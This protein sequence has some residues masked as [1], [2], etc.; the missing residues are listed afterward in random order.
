MFLNVLILIVK[1]AH[2]ITTRNS[3][4]IFSFH[5]EDNLFYV[6]VEKNE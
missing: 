6:R 5:Y 1:K 2:T 4:S 3:Q